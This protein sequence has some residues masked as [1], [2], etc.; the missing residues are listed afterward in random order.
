MG[1]VAEGLARLSSL[2]PLKERQV[3]LGEVLAAVHKGVLASFVENGR[4]LSNEEV[5]QLIGGDDAASALRILQT[6]DLVVLGADGA[7]VGSYPMTMEET[8]HRVK[9]NGHEINAMCALDSLGISPMFGKRV[10]I[11]SSC[12]ST[13]EPVHIEQDGEKILGAKPSQDVRFGII[14]NSPTGCCAHSLCT[15]MVFLKDKDTAEAWAKECSQREIYDLVEA[16]ELSA[17][18]FVPLVT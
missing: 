5:S 18:F 8:P 9:V 7:V 1:K 6:S 17:R 15:E 4:P 2:L 11:E 10:R 13:G 3:A 16:V 14:W 12:H